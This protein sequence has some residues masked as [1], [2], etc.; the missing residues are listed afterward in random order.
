MWNF[1]ICPIHAS[2]VQCQA[3][4]FGQCSGTYLGAHF[5]QF[6]VYWDKCSVTFLPD[7]TFIPKNFPSI[8]AQHDSFQSRSEVHLHRMSCAMWCT[9]GSEGRAT[10]PNWLSD[11]W[12][13]FWHA[14]NFGRLSSGS[15]TVEAEP[16]APQLS[17]SWA[18]FHGSLSGSLRHGQKT[19]GRSLFLKFSVRKIKQEFFRVPRTCWI[20]ANIC[21]V[22]TFCVSRTYLSAIGY[23]FKTKDAIEKLCQ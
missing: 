19:D 13:N 8:F 3:K 17:L 5:R 20:P 15:G 6:W 16:L 22:V 7:C 14:R 18:G 10:A 1:H 2:A 9:G 11:V 12:M 4:I 21:Q 23:R